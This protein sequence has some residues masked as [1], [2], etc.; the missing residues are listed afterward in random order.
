M[1][2]AQVNPKL[3]IKEQGEESECKNI[4]ILFHILRGTW[5]YMYV[6]H[7]PSNIK[8]CNLIRNCTPI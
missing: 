8:H 3:E 2:V 4:G 6:E 5:S 1:C 7:C